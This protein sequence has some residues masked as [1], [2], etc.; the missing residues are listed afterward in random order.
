MAGPPELHAHTHP[1]S[2]EFDAQG[3]QPHMHTF[4]SEA[5]TSLSDCRTMCLSTPPTRSSTGTTVMKF[6]N[7]QTAAV[8]LLCIY[9]ADGNPAVPSLQHTGSSWGSLLRMLNH[10]GEPSLCEGTQ[11]QNTCTDARHQQ[12]AH[13]VPSRRAMNTSAEAPGFGILLSAMAAC[14]CCTAGSSMLQPCRQRNLKQLASE[15]NSSHGL[16]HLYLQAAATLWAA[17]QACHCPPCV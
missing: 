12:A 4:G 17:W 14:S 9:A 16:Q 2:T 11:Q 13:L 7:L 15:H 6:L 1:C 8:Q 5:L 10:S 3:S